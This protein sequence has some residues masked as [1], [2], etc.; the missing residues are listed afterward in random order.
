MP[1]I[2]ALGGRSLVR[3]I[4]LFPEGSVDAGSS[5]EAAVPCLPTKQ[6][7]GPQP[8]T[9][10]EKFIIFQQIFINLKKYDLFS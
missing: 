5:C 3:G 4:R 7:H 2:H 10:P 9:A 1:G 8:V 6:A